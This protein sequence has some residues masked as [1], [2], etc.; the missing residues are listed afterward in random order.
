MALSVIHKSGLNKLKAPK[1]DADDHAILRLRSPYKPSLCL[2]FCLRKTKGRQGEG[3]ALICSYYKTGG[4]THMDAKTREGTLKVIEVIDEGLRQPEPAEEGGLDTSFRWI[5]RDVRR[6]LVN[7][8]V[9]DEFEQRY[10]IALNRSNTDFPIDMEPTLNAALQNSF[11]T[12]CALSGGGRPGDFL[13]AKEKICGY[14]EVGSYEALQKLPKNVK[15]QVKTAP[16]L[17]FSIS[18]YAFDGD[19]DQELFYSLIDEIKT[20]N[21]CKVKEYDQNSRIYI[22]FDMPEAKK[23]MDNCEEISHRYRAL[24]EAN[25]KKEELNR[26][27]REIKELENEDNSL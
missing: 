15:A 4:F 14:A 6:E 9:T 19:N 26:L 16:K 3:V 11:S 7:C 13:Y 21:P 1:L 8:L 18:K 10:G 24:A 25:T 22:Y 23:F 20:Y 27:K 5:G 17:C 12:S 2:A